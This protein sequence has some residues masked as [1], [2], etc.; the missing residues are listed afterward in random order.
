VCK[1]V[2]NS[3]RYRLPRR[4][5]RPKPGWI[6]NSPEIRSEEDRIRTYAENAENS[7]GSIG[8]GAESGTLAAQNGWSNPGLA[9]VVQSWPRLPEALY[10]GIL[11][12]VWAAC[13]AG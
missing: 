5:H 9:E 3:R 11:A 2:K 12:M 7:I 8:S 10:A 1:A 6:G 13:G 4:F